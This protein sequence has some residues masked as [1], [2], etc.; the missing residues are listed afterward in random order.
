MLQRGGMTT[1]TDPEPTP[2]APAVETIANKGTVQS[3]PKRKHWKEY[4]DEEFWEL[5]KGACSF[6]I[7]LA[8]RPSR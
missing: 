7:E 3:K 6:S 4:T 8:P 2:I 5:T 1:P